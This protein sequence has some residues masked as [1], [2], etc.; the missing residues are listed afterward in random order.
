[1]VSG[2]SIVNFSLCSM[3]TIIEFNQINTDWAWETKV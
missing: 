1:M 3:V 2:A